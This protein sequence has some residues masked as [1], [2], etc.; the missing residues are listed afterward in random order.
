MKKS[1]LSPR[2]LTF[3][4]IHVDRDDVGKV[5]EAVTNL[6]SVVLDLAYEFHTEVPTY[7]LNGPRT[8]VRKQARHRHIPTQVLETLQQGPLTVRQIAQT[9][10]INT[11]Q[12]STVL[13]SLCKHGSIIR[14]KSMKPS[15]YRLAQPVP[16]PAP[17]PITVPNNLA[18]AMRTIIEQVGAIDV[19]GLREKIKALGFGQKNFITN[20]KRLKAR[21]EIA[22]TKQK[23]EWRGRGTEA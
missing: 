3:I 7:H 16:P 22:W 2:H 9:V 4:H 15:L 10:G 21:K 18:D 1:D 19:E 12:M 13:W 20:L 17:A 23:I 11:H 8:A 6:G 14:D 5:L